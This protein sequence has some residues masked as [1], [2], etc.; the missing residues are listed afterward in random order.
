MCIALAAWLFSVLSFISK[1]IGAN[2]LKAGIKRRRTKAE[3]TQAKM[4]AELKEEAEAAK[5]NRIAD[6]EARLAATMNEVSKN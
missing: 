4:E 1:G 2:L 6:L 5:N 3:V